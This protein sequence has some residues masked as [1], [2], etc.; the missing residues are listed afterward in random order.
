VTYIS[1]LSQSETDEI[2][3]VVK[4]DFLL[5]EKI[6]TNISQLVEAITPEVKE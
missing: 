6:S 3:F 4:N 2:E 1:R 5:E